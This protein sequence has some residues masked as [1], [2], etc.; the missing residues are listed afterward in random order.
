MCEDIGLKVPLLVLN[1]LDAE[2]SSDDTDLNE[3]VF[4]TVFS[5]I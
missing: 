3:N 1:D 5:S 4:F 2:P